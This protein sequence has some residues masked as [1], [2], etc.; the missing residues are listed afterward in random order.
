M[1]S[2][3]TGTAPGPDGPPATGLAASRL[4]RREDM[5]SCEMAFVDCKL[6]GST[7][8][9]N[10]SIIG[11]GVTQSAD[12]VINISEPHGFAIG[13]A[14]MPYGITNNL[15]IH[16]TAEV[17]M[18]FRGE[19]LF[20]WGN[21]GDDGELIGRAGDVIS[22]PTW[23]FRGFTNI[24]SDDG[25]IFTALGRDESGG[26]IW[27]PGILR[28]AAETGVYLTRDNML[29]DIADGV[30]PPA[31]AER[32][33]PL[34]DAFIATLR[35]YTI[36]DLRARTTSAEDRHWSAG[37]LLDAGLPGHAS[38]LAPVIGHGM[39]QDRHAA[40]K[41][42][43]PHGFSI[44]WLRI[45]PGNQ[46]GPF[47]TGPKQVLILQEGRLEIMLGDGSVATLEPWGLFAMPGGVWRTLRSVGDVPALMTV[48][49]AGDARA[50]IEWDPAIVAAA[51][52]A[53]TGV[54]PNDYLCP[55]D[56]L[57]V[58]AAAA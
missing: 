42:T 32:M 26:V 34:T 41:V 19:W 48:T 44:E 8:K 29:V 16:Y 27:H 56:L 55:A 45:P 25:W 9:G 4:I 17:F 50:L 14:E 54:D 30:P 5:V 23:I 57:P 58:F 12:Q 33:T 47:R 22:I 40:P 11:A 20:R 39:T 52:T 28:A 38:E 49:T 1:Q 21:N 7:P 10:Y 6:P 37:G 53:G 51:L 18:I 2:A 46:V 35:R 3:L 36:D 15:H 43:N 13:V 24:G 31:D